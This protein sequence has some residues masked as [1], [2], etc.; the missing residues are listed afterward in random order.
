[1]GSN[2]LTMSRSVVEG[3]TDE[4]LL[5]TSPFMKMMGV[6]LFNEIRGIGWDSSLCTSRIPVLAGALLM[7][8]KSNAGPPSPSQLVVVADPN[9]LVLAVL[10][11]RILFERNQYSGFD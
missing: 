11:P 3:R 1:M 7:D 4:R 10:A 5:F 6:Y 9:G 8:S 2:G